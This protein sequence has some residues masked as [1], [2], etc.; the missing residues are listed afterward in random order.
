MGRKAVHTP[1]NLKIGDKMEIRGKM[2][3]YSWQYLNNFNKRGE[4][5][6]RHVK[7]G[8]KIFFERIS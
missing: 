6:Y 5:K 4:A 2:K 1:E 7:D 3:T 8:K